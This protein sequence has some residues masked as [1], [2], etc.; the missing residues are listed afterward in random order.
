MSDP[1]HIGLLLAIVVWWLAAA[2]LADHHAS[3]L[4]APQQRAQRS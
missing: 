1:L 3:H 2:I 4:G